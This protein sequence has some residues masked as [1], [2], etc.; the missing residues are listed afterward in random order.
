MVVVIQTLL[1]INKLRSI[2]N[3]LHLWQSSA[4]AADRL[5]ALLLLPPLALLVLFHPKAGSPLGDFRK[6]GSPVCY[7]PPFFPMCVT[8]LGIDAGGFRAPPGF[9]AQGYQQA[10]PGAAAYGQ[11]QAY[12]GYAG[13]QT[14]A[15][16]EYGSPATGGADAYAA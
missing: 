9:Q 16:G 8:N 15:V 14:G 3:T 13:Y 5:Q 11:Q 6:I 4:K 12:P 7:L 10:A 2:Q 1:R